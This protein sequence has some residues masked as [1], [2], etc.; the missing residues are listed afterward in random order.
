LPVEVA[1]TCTSQLCQK[2]YSL[3]LKDDI[4]L[5]YKLLNSF[6]RFMPDAVVDVPLW[7][8]PPARDG[9]WW[10]GQW[11]HTCDWVSSSM[12]S[13]VAHLTEHVLSSHGRTSDVQ[14]EDSMGNDAQ[15]ICTQMVSVLQVQL[16]G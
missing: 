1:V 11:K 2:P 10:K 3:P 13:T 16:L 9:D 8:W 7:Q 6:A 15:C 4:D 5:L 12:R 14:E